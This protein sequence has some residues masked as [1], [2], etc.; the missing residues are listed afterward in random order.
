[1]ETN[2]FIPEKYCFLSGSGLKIIAVISMLIDHCA[3]TFL[4][5]S[6]I[7]VFSVEGYTLTLYWL[8]RYIGRLAFPIFCFLIVEGFVHTSDRKKYGRNLL[9]FAFASEIPWNLWHSGTLL[10][11][12]QNVFFTLF[13]GYLGLCVIEKFGGV[14]RVLFLL[15]LLAASLLLR[16]DYGHVGYEFI[17][18]LYLLRKDRG[19]QAVVGSCI[20]PTRLFAGMAFIPINLYNGQ[21]GF[22][23][24]RWKYAFYLF[25]PAHILLLYFIKAHT[26]GY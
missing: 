6:D 7:A 23:C 14:K 5:D 11:S 1:M 4:A 18:L 20:L 12:K 17:L 3:A 13:L 25:Y 15:A 16:A 8:L 26:I 21:R 24:G 22:I 2:R 9:L 19:I 10:N